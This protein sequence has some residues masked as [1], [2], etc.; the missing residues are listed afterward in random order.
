MIGELR[1]ENAKLKAEID[2]LRDELH[3]QQVH[4][5]LRGPQA[6]TGAGDHPRTIDGDIAAWKMHLVGTTVDDAYSSATAIASWWNADKHGPHLVGPL[7][8][9]LQGDTGGVQT[10]QMSW[11]CHVPPDVYTFRVREGKI[12]EFSAD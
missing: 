11:P 7:R 10:W 2:D 12:I 4:D 1:E 3:R 8:P 5:K 9:S 6:S